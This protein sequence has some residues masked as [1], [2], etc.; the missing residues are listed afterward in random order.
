MEIW[1]I[2]R[3]FFMVTLT[4]LSMNFPNFHGNRIFMRVSTFG[5]SLVP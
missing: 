5:Q 2:L 3:L 1:K 4:E